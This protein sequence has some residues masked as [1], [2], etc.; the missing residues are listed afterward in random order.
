MQFKAKQIIKVMT[1]KELPGLGSAISIVAEPIKRG[2]QAI[3]PTPIKR[4]LDNCGCKE[5]K[6]KLDK[7]IEFI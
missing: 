2:I 7:I 3:S 4:L 1:G 5:R 6:D